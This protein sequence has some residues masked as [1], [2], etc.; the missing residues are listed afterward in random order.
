MKKILKRFFLFIN[1]WVVNQRNKSFCGQPLFQRGNII[2]EF[3]IGKLYGFKKTSDDYYTNSCDRVWSL[4]HDVQ[5]ILNALGHHARKIPY[6]EIW[7]IS[8]KNL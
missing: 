1:L 7:A 8:Q 3:F 4:P 5:R 2:S 6:S